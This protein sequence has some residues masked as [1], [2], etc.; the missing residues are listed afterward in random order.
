MMETSALV[1]YLDGDGYQAAWLP[2]V[3][4]AS[5]TLLLPDGGID[6]LLSRLTVVEV[7]HQGFIPVDEQGTEAAA[8]TAVVEAKPH[9]P[10]RPNSSSIALS[11]SS[12]SMSQPENCS[13]PAP[14]PILRPD[15]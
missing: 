14:W 1:G 7:V 13:S 12:S 6:D 2:Y 10:S 3:G 8:A 9:F 4:D 15:P 5:M 11:C